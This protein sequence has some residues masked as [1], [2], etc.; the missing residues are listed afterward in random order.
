MLTVAQMLT[1]VGDDPI[2][3]RSEAAFASSGEKTALCTAEQWIPTSNK[4]RTT[5]VRPEAVMRQM[6]RRPYLLQ[7]IWT[8]ARKQSP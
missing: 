8:L 5:F 4:E 2:Q 6:Y 1:R 7:T 3:I